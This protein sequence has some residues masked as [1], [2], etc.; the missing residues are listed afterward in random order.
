MIELIYDLRSRLYLEL[1]FVNEGPLHVG[2]ERAEGDLTL[3]IFQ[4][5]INNEYKPIIPRTTLKGIL[6]KYAELLMKSLNFPNREEIIKDHERD[7]ENKA[8]SSE[9]IN[10]LALRCPVC[11]LFGSKFYRARIKLTDAEPVSD[12][13]L[14]IKPGIKIDKKTRTIHEKYLF[15]VYSLSPGVK[16]RAI[17]IYDNPLHLYRGAEDLYK[18]PLKIIVNI[19]ELWMTHGILLGG[20]KTRGY[21]MTRLLGEESRG[22]LFNYEKMKNNNKIE[23]IVKSLQ[24]PSPWLKPLKEFLKDLKKLIQ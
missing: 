18:I 24:N 6:R 2:G 12:Y 15:Q 19:L 21:G 23:D 8:G 11:N 17:L 5:S 13:A 20:H 9:E 16:F 14:F 3:P 10:E 4:V 1:I 22:Y 7:H